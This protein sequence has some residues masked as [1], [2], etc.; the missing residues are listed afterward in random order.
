MP[1]PAQILLVSDF[2]SENDGL[3]LL[4]RL[5]AGERGVQVVTDEPAALNVVELEKPEIVFAHLKAGALPSIQFLNEVWKRNPKSARFLVADSI[6]DSD[7]LVRCVLGAHQFISK[8]V[9]K[10]TVVAALERADAIKRFVRNER[11][12]ALV[13]KMRT[14]PTR[15]SLYLDVMRELRSSTAS[16]ATVGELVSKDLAISTKLIQVVNSAFFGIEQQVT[17]PAAAV[18]LLGLEMTGS[19]VLSIEAFARFDKVKPLYFSIDRV[20]KHSQSVA[21]TARKICQAMNCEAEVCREAY[22]AG[23]LHDLGK[24]A[25]AQNFEEQ[26]DGALKLAEKQKLA[27]CEVEEQVFGASHAETGAYLLAIWGLALPIVEAVADHHLPPEKLPVPFSAATALHIAE[28]LA[29]NPSQLENVLAR[30]PA[31]FGLRA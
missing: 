14:L 20:W 8:P 7:A 10:P 5:I 11:I 26:Y 6:L 2:P 31:E 29:E 28:Q 4:L 17:D 22:T 1:G 18:L 13:S 23:L 25:L 30:Y 15:P 3:E 27:D 24:L 19:L 16:A 12:Q 9:D 21:D